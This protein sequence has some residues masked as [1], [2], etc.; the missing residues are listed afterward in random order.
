MA[1]S[2]EKPQRSLDLPDYWIGKTEVTNAQFRP[3]VE[4]DGYTNKDYWT[5]AGWDWRTYNNLVKPAYWD[6]SQWNGDTQPVVGISWFEAVAYCR[7]LSAQT[8]HEFRLPSEAEW[9]KAARGPDGRIWPWGNTWEANRAN[10]S[11]AG[12]GKTTPV[13]QYPN[14][15]SFYGVLDMAGN[16]YEWVATKQQSYPYQLEDEWQSAYLEAN[17]APM[18]RGGSYYIWQE[19]I[20]GAYRRGGKF[21]RG[22]YRA[23]AY[24][25]DSNDD[26][27]GLRVASHS[28]MPGK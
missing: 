7:W 25:P 1:K 5:S 22:G 14:G 15:A 9:E 10:S 8:G 27:I 16:A 2:E 6:D 20:R 17:L 11:E 13:G 18:L 28:P 24:T 23:F 19:T 21:F 4:G 26:D 3:F 12:I